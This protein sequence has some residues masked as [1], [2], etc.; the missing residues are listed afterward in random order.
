[1]FTRTISY[2]VIAAVLACPLWCS[3]SV[4]FCC[5]ADQFT[6]QRC[7]IA[8]SS[9]QSTLPVGCCQHP[10]SHQGSK[11]VESPTRSCQGICGGAVFE[12]TPELTG[13]ECISFL[14]ILSARWTSVDHFA[15]RRSQIG[16][17][18]LLAHGNIGRAVRTLEMSFLC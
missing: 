10:T 12:K 14:P 15:A 5:H 2:L 1:M 6:A 18:P 9:K 17:P 16:A 3:N 8:S 7:A 4:C 13:V 11:P